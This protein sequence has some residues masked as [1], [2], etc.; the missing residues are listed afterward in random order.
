MHDGGG[1]IS[2]IETEPPEPLNSDQ[3][4]SEEDKR[5]MLQLGDTLE[6]PY[7]LSN[8]L[9][10]YNSLPENAMARLAFDADQI[11]PT[12]HYMKFYPKNEVELELLIEDTTQHFYSYP[13]DV[14]ISDT[15]TFYYDPT[16]PISV[17]TPQYVAMPVNQSFPQNI[18]NEIIYDLY[19]PDENDFALSNDF[20]ST[21][22]NGNIRSFSLL[23][24]YY[25]LEDMTDELTGNLP[26]DL[27]GYKYSD[28]LDT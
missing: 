13:L 14:E 3:F 11:K 8:V 6:N 27:K 10:A 4:L 9:K 2:C 1:G 19:M 17:P 21:D 18:K 24:A 26:V 28:R 7:K 20:K 15:G 25:Q 5:Q 16:I 22:L 23:E 12:H